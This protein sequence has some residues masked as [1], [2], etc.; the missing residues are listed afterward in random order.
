[1]HILHYLLLS[2]LLLSTSL[3]S[4]EITKDNVNFT[5]REIPTPAVQAF[6]I[7]RGFSKEQIKAYSDTCVYTTTLRND[8]TNQ[9]IHYIRKDW[10]VKYHNKNLPIQSN[11]YWKEHFKKYK[12]TPA[13]WIGF[14]L[15]QMP[16]EQTYGANGGWNQ[17]ILSVNVPHGN[18]F[19]L[20][21]T[22]DIKGKKNAL[23]LKG[24]SCEK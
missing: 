14:R 11:N 21:I 13:S 5:I 15:S 17:G 24:I 12:I 1:M 18:S 16:E 6:Y 7:A 4:K 23:T 3:L 19:D 20:T 22:W 2:S 10:S 8:H 9:E